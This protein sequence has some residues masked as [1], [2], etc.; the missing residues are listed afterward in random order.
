M[1][2]RNPSRTSGVLPLVRLLVVT[3]VAW[4]LGCVEPPELVPRDPTPGVPYV[5]VTTFNV[6]YSEWDDP[7][8]IAAVGDSNAD[9]LTLQEVGAD[10]QD[11]L[12]DTYAEAYPSMAFAGSGSGGLAI[13]SKF[14]FE[15]RGVHPG[16]DGW[17]PA[18]HVVVASPVGPLQ[19]LMVHLRP[20]VSRR[21]GYTTS[22]F[23][24]G[25]ARA[26]EIRQFTQSCN[27]GLVTLVMGDFNEASGRATSYL[28]QRGF[29][30]VLPLYR[31]GQETWRY[32]K[33]LLGQA[34]DTLDHVFFPGTLAPL[35]A[36]ATYVG[37]S[38][39]LPVTALFELADPPL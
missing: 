29:R 5:S 2:L 26:Q 14:P 7:E 12:R 18:W 19:L 3:V 15:D 23:E 16:L 27:D 6:D 39:H 13:L 25:S 35:N 4:A 38:D 31:P 8:T 30:S 9:I 34:V 10:W 33:S 36:Y 28:R 21:E 24:S 11:T 22:Y 17:H 32:D 37:N 20:T 1:F